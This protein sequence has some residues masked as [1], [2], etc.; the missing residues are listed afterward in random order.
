MRSFY[1]TREIGLHEPARPVPT[2]TLAESLDNRFARKA[3][4]MADHYATVARLAIAARLP[5]LAGAAAR[6]ATHWAR[7][8]QARSAMTIEYVPPEGLET[9]FAL[10]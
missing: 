2:P 7:V 6:A 8:C 3:G 4:L 1:G 9:G 10:L 5:M